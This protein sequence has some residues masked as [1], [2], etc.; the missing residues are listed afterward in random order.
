MTLHPDEQARE[1]VQAILIK[2]RGAIALTDEVMALLASVRKDAWWEAEQ[3][4]KDAY[5]EYEE[6]LIGVMWGLKAIA[7]LREVKRADGK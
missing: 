4:F 5:S 6:P 2:V 3:A 1:S 7:N